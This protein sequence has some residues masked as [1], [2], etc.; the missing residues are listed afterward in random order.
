MGEE[1][2]P[3]ELDFALELF[4]SEVPRELAAGDGVLLDYGFRC[5]IGLVGRLDGVANRVSRSVGP[6]GWMNRVRRLGE[7]PEK[8]S[9]GNVIF[10]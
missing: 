9:L 5:L 10:F 3:S 1:T 6:M 4:H 8:G 7:V 2:V